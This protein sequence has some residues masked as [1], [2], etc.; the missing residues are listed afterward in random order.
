MTNPPARIPLEEILAKHDWILTFAHP[1]DVASLLRSNDV[2]SPLQSTQLKASLDGLKEPLAELQSDLG[3]LRNAVVSLETRMLR[4]QLLKLDYE[5]ALSP[6]RRLPM[7]VVAEN[8]RRSWPTRSPGLS[9]HFLGA[10][11]PRHGPWILGH[12]CSLWRSVIETLCPEL[13]A[14]LSFEN[15][16]RYSGPA[17]NSLQRLCCV[18]E[19]SRNHPLDFIY[20]NYLDRDQLMDQCFE[21][22]AALSKRWRV[23]EIRLIPFHIPR[24]SV[25]G[26]IDWLREVY[27]SCHHCPPPPG[28]IRAFEIAPKLEILHLKG[29]HP[30]ANICFPTTNLISFSDER[31]SVDRLLPEYLDIVKS[32]SKL[33]SFSYVGK[34]I[35]TE[36]PFSRI[37]SSTLEELSTSSLDFICSMKLPALKEFKLILPRAPGIDS[38]QAVHEMVLCSQCSLTRLSIQNARLDE[39]LVPILRLTPH[40]EEFEITIG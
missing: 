7:E 17:D 8:L 21:I 10:S 35:Q 29:I 1:P 18:L 40:L 24:L 39:S 22:M 15:T 9:A 36:A 23:V 37:T 12:V 38:L 34:S 5:T 31:E 28:D 14:T 32:A 13:W 19:R 3:L 16:Y 11:N 27:L 26:K 2:P 30:D 25:H 33:R 20:A 4:L 6:I